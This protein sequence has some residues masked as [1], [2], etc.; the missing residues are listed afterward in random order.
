[1][2][3]TTPQE[4]LGSLIAEIEDPYNIENYVLILRQ[5]LT[6][7]EQLKYTNEKLLKYKE[8]WEDATVYEDYDQLKAENAALRKELSDGYSSP[9]AGITTFLG[10]PMDYWLKLQESN[11]ALRE[12]VYYNIDPFDMS[13]EHREM[14]DK[15]AATIEERK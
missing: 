11:A 14:Y 12:L 9:P 7:H 6:E 4:A 5:T 10:K 2:T 1:M 15:H 3:N 8:M 13:K